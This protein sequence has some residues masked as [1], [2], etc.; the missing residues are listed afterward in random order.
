M[1][2]EATQ[3]ESPPGFATNGANGNKAPEL[4]QRAALKEIV[5][6]RW[7]REIDTKSPAFAAFVA[8]IKEHGIIQ[9]LICRPL[10]SALDSERKPGSP[11]LEIVAGERR[12]LGAERAGLT[13]V[14]VIVRRLSD[15]DALEQQAIE[16]EQRADLN[17]IERAEKYQQLLDEYTRTGM[18][19]EDAIAELCK[20][21]SVGKSSEIGKSTVYEALRLLTLPP[22]IKK[23]LTTG[24]LPASHAGLIAKLPAEYQPLYAKAI[25]PGKSLT[26]AEERE[27]EELV[28]WVDARDDDTGLIPFRDAKEIVDSAL[29]DIEKAQAYE[30]VAVEF[31]KKGGTALS[32]AESRARNRDYVTSGD[33]LGEYSRYVHEAVKGVK[34]LP[35][36]VMQPGRH[37]PAKPEMVYDRKALLAALKKAGVKPRSQSGGGTSMAD[38]NRREKERQARERI[39]KAALTAAIAPIR[40]AA[41]KRNAKI[42]W[43]LF[44]VAMAGWTAGRI[45]ERRGWKAKHN[46]AGKVLAEHLAKMPENQ[47]PGLVADILID[48][49]TTEHT[50]HYQPEFVSLGKFYGV[51]VKAIA[52]AAE[53]KQAP[54]PTKK[55][56]AKKEVQTTGKSKGKGELTPA[57]RKKLNDAMKARWAARRKAAK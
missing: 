8:N 16:N 34:E 4:V 52:K 9:P 42:P 28:G 26:A 54:P 12:W 38:Y 55:P 44:I 53:A 56:Q 21:L 15:R 1:K 18:K 45:C 47:M 10:P 14:P 36:M 5:R 27:I 29:Q 35:K 23:A 7:N 40:E 49:V 13:D 31:R 51:D 57:A 41:G 32:L 46:N 39:A 20:K 22:P 48:K 30:L 17:P 2:S 37:D 33:Y 50:G 25:A 19:K 24:T 11:R 43:P 3:I 6:S